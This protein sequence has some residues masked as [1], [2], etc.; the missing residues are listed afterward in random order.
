[1]PCPLSSTVAELSYPPYFIVIYDAVFP[2]FNYFARLPTDD[3]TSDSYSLILLQ[4][5]I[6]CNPRAT[7]NPEVR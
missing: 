1:M 6:V 2:L 7:Y 5:F 3:T 4:Y